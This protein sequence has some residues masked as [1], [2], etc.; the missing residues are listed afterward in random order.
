MV[1]TNRRWGQGVGGMDLSRWL[2]WFNGLCEH[3]QFF[4]GAIDDF[5]I[6]SPC[7]VQALLNNVQ[8]CHIAE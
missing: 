1:G 7:I 4:Q 3:C 5:D 8:I 6:I 2:Y